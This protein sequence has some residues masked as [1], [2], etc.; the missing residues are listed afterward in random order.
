MNDSFYHVY[1]TNVFTKKIEYKKYGNYVNTVKVEQK[2]DIRDTI[3]RLF[4]FLLADANSVRGKTMILYGTSEY[5]KKDGIVMMDFSSHVINRIVSNEMGYR[6]LEMY[7]TSDMSMYRIMNNVLN[8]LVFGMLDDSICRIFALS[9]LQFVHIIHMMFFKKNK[10]IETLKSVIEYLKTTFTNA[11]K[12]DDILYTIPSIMDD[13][14]ANSEYDRI[15]DILDRINVLTDIQYAFK[16]LWPSLNFISFMS[17]NGYDA[18]TIRYIKRLLPDIELHGALL[19][20]PEDIIGYGIDNDVEYH[21]TNPSVILEYESLTHNTLYDP[22]TEPVPN[23]MYNLIV[24]S[25]KSDTLRVKTNEIVIYL[26]DNYIQHICKRFDLVQI[27]GTI[28]TPMHIEELLHD[29]VIDYCYRTDENGMYMF[30]LEFEMNCYTVDK[31]DEPDK[32]IVLR[33]EYTKR[34]NLIRL[35]EPFCIDDDSGLTQIHIE[36]RAVKP[37]TFKKIRESRYAPCISQYELRLERRLIDGNEIE[38]L[39]NSIVHMYI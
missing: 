33:K 6:Y 26:G 10:L 19:A 11:T 1:T 27:K 37:H 7:G 4:P 31:V 39:K 2:D 17:T 12:N 22:Y 9:P 24:S 23:H 21:T 5:D 18:L 3:E 25:R 8:H 29:K 38:I 15:T 20:F 35:N 32:M 30:Y 16:E 34:D 36:V 13:K 28:L 14:T